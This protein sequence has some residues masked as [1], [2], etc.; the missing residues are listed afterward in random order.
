[1]QKEQIE[2]KIRASRFWY[3]FT[4]YD[5]LLFQFEELENSSDSTHV[6]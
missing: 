1:M 4:L 6:H 2:E 5:P 3:Q